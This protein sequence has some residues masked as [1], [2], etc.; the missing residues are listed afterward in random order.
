MAPEAAAGQPSPAWLLGVDFSCA[1]AAR[2]PIVAAWGRRHGAVVKL[3]AL[4]QIVTLEGFE[5]LLSPTHPRSAQG[6]IG[7]FDFP[8]GLPRVFVDALRADSGLPLADAR[9]LITHLRGRCPE[10]QAFQRLIDAWGQQWG[11]GTRPATLPHRPCDTAMAGVSS[12]SPLQTRYVPV[13]KMYFEGLWRLVQAGIDLPGLLQDTPEPAGPAR[14]AFEAYP[15]FLAHEIL[16]RQSYKT[17][18]RDQVDAARRLVQRLSLIDALEQGRTR[19]GLRLKLTPAQRD[20]LASDPQGDRVDAVLCLLQAGWADIRRSQG[21]AR[22]AQPHDMDRVEG[23][24]L[25]A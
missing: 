25:S 14:I 5:A 23:W 2:K 4:E 6:W 24:I 13:G 17:D 18:A 21:D 7:G 22:A 20:H 3:E 1:P 19:L 9:E 10:R 8:F 15:G 12:T 11:Q 16:G